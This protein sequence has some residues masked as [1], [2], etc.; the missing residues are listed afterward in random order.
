MVELAMK[1]R[2]SLPYQKRGPTRD[3]RVRARIIRSGEIHARLRSRTVFT[4]GRSASIASRC[5]TGKL[6]STNAKISRIN[7]LYVYVIVH[8]QAM[9]EPLVKYATKQ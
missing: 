4:G 8:A 1:T 7:K 2:Y 6:K 9:S 3:R 5:L